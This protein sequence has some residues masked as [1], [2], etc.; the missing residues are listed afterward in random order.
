MRE[1]YKKKILGFIVYDFF[2]MIIAKIIIRTIEPPI[3]ILVPI[4]IRFDDE[5]DWVIIFKII[6]I[7]VI[8]I[9]L[10]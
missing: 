2:L 5:E 8:G 7:K 10:L 9:F 1:K 4:N 3:A 6:D